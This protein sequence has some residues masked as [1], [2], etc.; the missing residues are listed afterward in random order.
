MEKLSSSVGR[1]GDN[2][3]VD[4]S[5]IQGLLNNYDIPGVMEPLIIDGKA[6]NKTYA[7]IEAFQKKF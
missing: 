4:V 3:S 2:K 5:L 7:R 6:G 1:E